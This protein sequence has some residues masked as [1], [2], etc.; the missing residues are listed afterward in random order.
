MPAPT[1]DA[2][3][4]VQQVGEYIDAHFVRDLFRL[5]TRDVLDVPGDNGLVRDYLAGQPMPEHPWADAVRREVA[6]GKIT[7][8]V[9]AL[10]EPLTDYRRM[11]IEWQ[12]LRNV[13][14]GERCRLINRADPAATAVG[15][16]DFWMIEHQHVLVM[17]YDQAGRFTGASPVTDPGEI[18]QWQDRARLAWD[19][20]ADLA[21][22]WDQHPQYQR[23]RRD[24][25]STGHVPTPRSHDDPQSDRT[26]DTARQGTARAS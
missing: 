14:A 17:H 18:R 4:S 5:E 10:T 19:L 6:D 26:D 2:R 24:G 21:T 22:W 23:D 8:R 16:L 11:S 3:M 20:G 9:L 15:E 13:A 7:R 1:S 25:G 12:Y